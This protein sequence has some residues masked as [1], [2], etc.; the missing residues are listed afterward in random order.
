MLEFH[1]ISTITMIATRASTSSSCFSNSSGLRRSG[2]VEGWPRRKRVNGHQEPHCHC[3]S[4]FKFRFPWHLETSRV[5]HLW[6][7]NSN[8]YAVI[9]CDLEEWRWTLKLN[10]IL[11]WMLQNSGIHQ[12]RL[13]V[14]P[15][16]FRVILCYICRWY[17]ISSINNSTWIHHY[18]PNWRLACNVQVLKIHVLRLWT[19]ILGALGWQLLIPKDVKSMELLLDPLKEESSTTII[20][21]NSFKNEDYQRLSSGYHLALTAQVRASLWW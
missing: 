10:K 6:E 16:I 13:V 1:G 3:V 4:L 5:A 18:R 8:H 12:L 20:V 2:S 19:T 21:L 7:V 17:R 11:L 14:Y 15:I 9:E